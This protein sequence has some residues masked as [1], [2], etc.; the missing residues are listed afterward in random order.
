MLLD[1]VPVPAPRFS[2]LPEALAPL[3][4][5]ATNLRW[6]WRAETRDL[7]ARIDPT[8]WAHTKNPIRLLH[9]S[10]VLDNASKDLIAD[11]A[12]EAKALNQY[13]SSS[14]TWYQ[15]EGKKYVLPG[16]GPIAYFC[17]EFGIHESFPIYSGG[18]GILAGDHLKE[19]SD[20]GL[21]LIGIGLFYRHGFF[22]Q[23]VDWE[24]RQE[25]IYPTLTSPNS[26]ILPA[27]GKD[28]QPLKVEIDFPGR[29]VFAAVW[30]VAVGRIPLILL[31]TDLPE[32]AQEDR[33][34]T[35]QLYTSGRDM[36]LHQEL[37]LGVG[38]ARAL[39][40]L[41]IKPS[42]WHMN[43]GHSSLLLLERLRQFAHDGM[44]LKV[45]KEKVRSSSIISIHTPVPAGNETFATTAVKELSAAVSG[46]RGFDTNEIIKLG[47]G[48]DADPAVFD[49]TA[50]ALRL[51]RDANGVSL[52]HGE[53]ADK[54]WKKIAGHHVRGVTNGVH[55]P[56]WLGPEVTRVFE[57]AKASFEDETALA[58]VDGGKKR[59]RWSGIDSVSPED[60]WQAHLAQ[61]RALIEFA[62]QRLFDQHARHGEGPA[63]LRAWLDSMNPDALTIGFARRFATYKRA[64]LLFS[65]EKRLA[66]LLKNTDRPVQIV[67]A[68]KAHPADRAG[69]ALIA[70]VYAKTQAKK[71]QGKVFFLEEYDIQ[72]GKMLVQGVDF[73]LNNPRRPLEASGT[74]G[75]KA[76]ANGAPNVSILDGWWDEAY[77]G[78][79]LRNG[80]AIGDRHTLSTDHLQDKHDAEALFKVLEDEV[81][82]T[83]F[84]RDKAGVPQ[85]WVKVMKNSIAS[86]IWPFSTARML[87]DYMKLMYGA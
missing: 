34:I 41:G 26:P 23:S 84:K 62:R 68:G 54:T 75:M 9:E 32:N 42:V 66:K 30:R 43:E 69:Q 46:E 71:F 48:V 36:R 73:W 59:P 65:D 78:G 33:P 19:A 76:A 12:K 3:A 13:L 35:S 67:F 87:Q 25:H 8:Y 85:E 21:P 50:F 74:S 28:G 20:L 37:V 17:A 29:K 40:E 57:R 24:G 14:D 11:V 45:A 10:E 70:K 15:R 80:W 60:L 44:S 16:A 47:S 64:T 77:E 49:M 52:L 7:F 22:H 51:T 82:P 79:K 56:T 53:T 83:F 58:L 86:S 38:G 39:A 5:L 4:N 55:M 81:I 1:S 61:K 31:D 63:Q 6:A 2:R 72:T 18:L 27:L